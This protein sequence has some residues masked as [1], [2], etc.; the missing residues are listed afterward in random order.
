M[1]DYNIIGTK[2]PIFK[3]VPYIGVFHWSEQNFVRNEHVKNGDWVSKGTCIW[4]GEECV[5]FEKENYKGG[6]N[7]VIKLKDLRALEVGNDT[8]PEK[9]FIKGLPNN[10]STL[11]RQNN[12]ILKYLNA[13]YNTNLAFRETK[14]YFEKD[15]KLGLKR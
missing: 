11:D 2:L 7:Y 4:G 12:V 3:E 1:K 9:W 8:F 13:K 6:L 15:S 14:W 10:I 5:L